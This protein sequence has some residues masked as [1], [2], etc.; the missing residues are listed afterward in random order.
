[1]LIFIY[2]C[3]CTS[4]RMRGYLVLV[5]KYLFAFSVFGCACSLLTD[6]NKFFVLTLFP[7]WSS[8]HIIYIYII[9]VYSYSAMSAYSSSK[10]NL[11]GKCIC[12]GFCVFSENIIFDSAICGHPY[13]VNCILECN[14]AIILWLL[15]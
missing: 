2:N 7:I 3:D 5:F 6:F 15:C 14:G 9:Y 13:L 4:V 12:C 10:T 8:P 1:M 11:G